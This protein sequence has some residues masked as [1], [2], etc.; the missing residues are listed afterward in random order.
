MRGLGLCES[1]AEAGFF[2]FCIHVGLIRLRDYSRKPPANNSARLRNFLA[3]VYE[4]KK[5][6]ES[7]S[8][9]LTPLAAGHITLSLAD[10]SSWWDGN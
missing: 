4:A 7:P 10:R 6:R 9:E 2:V 3:T 8:K 5:K 1:R